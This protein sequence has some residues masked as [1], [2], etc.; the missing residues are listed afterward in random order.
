MAVNCTCVVWNQHATTINSSATNPQYLFRAKFPLILINN[1]ICGFMT[2][3]IVAGLQIHLL[4]HPWVV[5]ITYTLVHLS[6]GGYLK[7]LVIMKAVKFLICIFVVLVECRTG[8]SLEWPADIMQS[9]WLLNGQNVDPILVNCCWGVDLHHPILMLL[10]L[11]HPS[12]SGNARIQS[13]M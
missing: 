6:R 12:H 2:S 10:P 4:G 8:L 7:P 11:L 3:H 13:H 1:P 5:Q 9:D